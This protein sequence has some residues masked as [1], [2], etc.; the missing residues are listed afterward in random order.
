MLKKRV[1]LALL[2]VALVGTAIV[3]LNFNPA[4]LVS[5]QQRKNDSL[6]RYQMAYHV[7]VI[8][9]LYGYPLVDMQRQMHNETHRL[10][11]GQQVLAPVNSLLSFS[12]YCRA[13]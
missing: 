9:Y 11:Q 6:I 10:S 4:G 1:Y 3:A 7:G 2:V 8:A 5:S 13:T 12:R